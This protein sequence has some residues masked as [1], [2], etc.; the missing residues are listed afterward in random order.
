[1]RRIFTEM[2][3]MIL[4]NGRRRRM[5]PPRSVGAIALL[6]LAL[7]GGQ[8]LAVAQ[9]AAPCHVTRQVGA[10]TLLHGA[11]ETPLSLGAPVAAGD[12]IVTHAGGRLEVTCDD[13]STITVG[14]A[15]NVSLAIFQ[16]AGD[17]RRYN[18]LLRLL[19]GILRLH[20]A[21]D[22]KRDRF[23]VMTDTAITSV[24]STQWIVDAAPG[25]TAVFVAEGRV[26]VSGTGGRGTVLLGPGFGTD[27]AAGAAPTQPKAWGQARIDQVMARTTLP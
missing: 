8:R 18:R 2:V 4:G 7:L 11:S 13:G 25:K 6:A 23:D 10:A 24:R 17:G 12:R 15:T 27:V 20:A 26:A 19:G 21:P 3:S 14:E 5:S 16:G 1:L 22:D 9:E